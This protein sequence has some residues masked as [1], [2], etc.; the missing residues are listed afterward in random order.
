MLRGTSRNQEI[1]MATPEKVLIT[2][3]REVG[4]LTAFAA[5][6]SEGFTALGIPSEVVSPGQ[7]F[8]RW[9]DLRDPSVLKILS[10]TAVFAA[11]FARR[12]ICV[13]HGFP[14]ADAQGWRRMLAI[15]GSFKLANSCSHAPL[16]AVSDYVAAHLRGLFNLKVA[17]TI[18]NPVQLSF[19]EPGAEMS[20]RHYLTYVGRLIPAKNLHRLL[21]AMCDL[22]RENPDLRICVI[23]DGPQRAELESS[24]RRDP[25]IEFTGDLD[26]LEVRR[27]LQ[28]TKVFVSGNEMEPFGITYL[29]ALSQGCAIGMPACGGGVEIAPEFVGTRVQLLPLSFDRQGLLS[30]LRRALN[31]TGTPVSLAGYEPKAVAEAYLETDKSLPVANIEHRE[32]TPCASNRYV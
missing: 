24:F 16:V 10:T 20:E 1:Q 4:G 7:I 17:A 15:L 28:R 18:R 26:P 8:K 27:Y 13:A 3:G 30:A 5:G 9:R 6:L 22:Q 19:L 23:G 21:P 12:A 31:S 11:P 32:R 2:G 25:P 29:E 14:R